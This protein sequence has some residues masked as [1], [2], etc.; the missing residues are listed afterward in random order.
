MSSTGF[1]STSNLYEPEKERILR[2]IDQWL[3]NGGGRVVRVG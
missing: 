3:E 2:Y 1:L